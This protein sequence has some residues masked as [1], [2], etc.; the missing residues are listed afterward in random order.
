M[1]S[2]LTCNSMENKE[3]ALALRPKCL[4]HKRRVDSAKHWLAKYKDKITSL[5]IVKIILASI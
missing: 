4:N 5:K 1:R 3:K 2:V